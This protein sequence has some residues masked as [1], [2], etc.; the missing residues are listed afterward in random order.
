MTTKWSAFSAGTQP[1]GADQ[2]PGLQGG[3]NVR[4]THTQLM[5]AILSL[6][7]DTDVT[8][9]ANSDSKIATQKAVKAY[10]DSLASGSG[11]TNLARRTQVQMTQAALALRG[12]G[13]LRDSLLV[14]TGALTA[15][16]IA[17]IK[18]DSLYNAWPVICRLRGNKL[19]LAYSAST[20]HHDN[21]IGNSCGQIGTENLD[22]TITWGSQ[23][24]IYDDSSKWVNPYG[25]TQ[26]SSGR[27]IVTQWRDTYP[28][29]GTGEAGFVYSDDDGATWSAWQSLVS[30]SG[31][32]RESYCSGAAIELDNG[33]V[34]IPIE[35]NNTGQTFSNE[36]IKV[37]RSTDANTLT[38]APTFGSPVYVHNYTSD[39]TPFYE[40]T[41]V[42][43]R[44]RSILCV[45][46]DV[47][48]PP[49]H[50]Y[51]QRSTDG[52]ATWGSLVSGPLG[53]GKPNVIQLSNGLVVLT[54]RKNSDASVIAYTSIDDGVTWDS[55]TVLDATMYEME[56]A[57]PVE[58]L[59][60]KVCVVY[61][62][63]P[64]SSFS[65]CDI[66]S[67]MVAVATTRLSTKASGISIV[68][69][70]ALL[71]ATDVEAALQELAAAIS[72]LGAGGG[73]TYGVYLGSNGGD[74]AVTS[75]SFVDITGWSIA[76][77]AAVND[78]IE[79]E[80]SGSGALTNVSSVDLCVSVAGTDGARIS[81]FSNK[82]G[83]TCAMLFGHKHTFTV[84]APMISGGTVTVQAR[85]RLPSGGTLTIY[86]SGDFRGG[87][88]AKNW[89]T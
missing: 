46:R 54:T 65:N 26:L 62:H 76:I 8:L 5:A 25:V 11:G 50:H 36:S 83:S 28:T 10:A 63:Q 23:F 45:H 51:T 66:K 87:M 58:L 85:A 22:G 15:G 39:S 7:G 3:V 40:S 69:V 20:G 16:T 44:D 14:P 21:N 31:F 37:V 53:Y 68:D 71:T 19:L 48:G 86:N 33:D 64:T 81:E 24:T 34:L 43:L 13:T 77:A 41:L 70:G 60:G 1:V 74:I 9:A 57:C 49:G 82:S 17:T 12:D 2:Y 78:R 35:G 47:A 18:D 67:V 30:A 72:G 32:T 42:L 56:Y 59:N 27:I 88:T 29:A 73:P 52:G 89:H 79:V 80:F 55:G 84:T 38:G 6:L 61:G 4:W 75:A